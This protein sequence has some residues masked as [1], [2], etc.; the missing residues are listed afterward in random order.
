MVCFVTSADTI[1]ECRCVIWF[2]ERLVLPAV[3]Y[4]VYSGTV[5]EFMGF[6]PFVFHRTVFMTYEITVVE[7]LDVV[8][9]VKFEAPAVFAVEFHY[10]SFVRGFIAECRY[11]A[12]DV[13]RFAPICAIDNVEVYF[14][15]FFKYDI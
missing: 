13:K 10:R 15:G 14:H 12:A 6:A 4:V 9:N 3:M 7:I 5:E 1:C 2:V 11:V 8:R